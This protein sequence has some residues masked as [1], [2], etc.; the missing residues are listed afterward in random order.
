MK[1][2]SRDP[3]PDTF[4]L[5]P[6]THLHIC[7]EFSGVSSISHSLAKYPLSLSTRLSYLFTERVSDKLRDKESGTFN[8]TATREDLFLFG[9]LSIALLHKHL[10]VPPVLYNRLDS[11]AAKASKIHFSSD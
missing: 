3:L 6:T 8:S 10:L 7:F 2:M 5:V 4:P 9:T 11:G 1:V